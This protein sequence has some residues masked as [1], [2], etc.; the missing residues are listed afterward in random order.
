MGDQHPDGAAVYPQDRMDS[1]AR[2]P[3]LYGKVQKIILQYREV[4]EQGI[5][6]ITVPT[7]HGGAGQRGETGTVGQV[8]QLGQIGCVS[9]LGINFLKPDN[10]GA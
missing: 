2:L 8:L 9:F 6:V 7:K 1:A 4:C 5:A 3:A 10:V